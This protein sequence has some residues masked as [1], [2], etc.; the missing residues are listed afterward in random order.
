MSFLFYIFIS[1]LETPFRKILEN[2]IQHE[3]KAFECPI[4]LNACP[5]YNKKFIQKIELG[6]QKPKEFMDVMMD[7]VISDLIKPLKKVYSFE[8]KYI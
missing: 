5:F 8:S 2:A 7:T 4:L 1:R 6:Q 3:E